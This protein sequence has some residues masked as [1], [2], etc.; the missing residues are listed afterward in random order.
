MKIVIEIP[1]YIK[2]QVDEGKGE[3]LGIP[4]WLCYGI[5]NGTPLPKGHGDLVD[6]KSLDRL[7]ELDFYNPDSYYEFCT[8]MECGRILV[9]ADEEGEEDGR[10]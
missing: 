3:E 5:A 7:W 4:L 10:K 2:E 1:N 6:L 9:E 8:I